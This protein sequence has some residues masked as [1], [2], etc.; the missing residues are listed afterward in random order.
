MALL[1]ELKQK[2][3]Q[4]FSAFWARYP[5]RTAKKDATKAWDQVVKTP[6]TEE[7]IHAA[8][9]WQIP[10][11]ASLD[12]Y[13]PPLPATYLRQE[14]FTD[15]PMKKKTISPP[16][17]RPATPEQ[18]QQSE[19]VARIQMLIHHGMEPEAAKRK[20]YLELGWIKEDQS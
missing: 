14:R 10:Y 2:L 12:W 7:L 15:E 17:G 6:Q 13:T 9:D 16:I 20:T 1:F 11:W 5:N 19:A 8:L 4:G 3:A 18:T